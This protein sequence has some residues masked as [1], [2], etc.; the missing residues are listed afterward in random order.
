MATGEGF[1]IRPKHVKPL[2]AFGSP[3]TGEKLAT[4]P[5]TVKP[6]VFCAAGLRCVYFQQ[7][8]KLIS[9]LVALPLF[10]A[11]L[12]G[13]A[14][15]VW[16]WSVPLGH[17]SAFLWIPPDCKQVR[18]V[19]VGQNNMIEEGILEHQIMRAE[20]AKLGIAEIFIAPPFE[21]WQNATNN[22]AA[23]VEFSAML[24][25][26]ATDSGYGELEFAPVTPIGHSAMASYPW[27]FAA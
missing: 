11:S 20:L 18:A 21:S 7:P 12:T 27:N 19:V 2:T 10:C 13:R 25:T 1:R 5:G 22:D 24:K 6:E 9:Y 26:L 8:M 15:A 17:G 23:N 4:G 16:Q 14:D 3:Y